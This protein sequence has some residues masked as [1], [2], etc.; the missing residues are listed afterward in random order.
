MRTVGTVREIHRYPLKS[1]AGEQLAAVEVT[2]AGLEHDRRWALVTPS[3]EP[4]TAREA[5]A[6][7]DVT[8]LLDGGRLAVRVPGADPV[9]GQGALAALAQ[10]AGTPVRWEE[11]G[12]SHVDVAAVHLVSAG[13][14][15]A[16]DAPGGCDPEPRAN[17]V[18]EL[19]AGPG[20]ER[21]WVGRRLAVGGAELQVTRTPKRCLGVYAE[22]LVPGRVEVGDA[23]RLAEA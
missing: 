18:L 15:S 6:L 3:G 10:V 11:A 20:G 2:A 16:D 7:R 9:A 8:A 23:V 1:A 19:E 12:T 21:A 22:V 4:V 14:A 13:A 5:P 17:L